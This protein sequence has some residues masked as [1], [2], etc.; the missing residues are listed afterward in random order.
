MF[1]VLFQ[2]L[3]CLNVFRILNSIYLGREYLKYLSILFLFLV[4]LL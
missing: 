4:G 3:S 2:C 1:E